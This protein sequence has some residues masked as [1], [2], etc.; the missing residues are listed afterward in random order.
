MKPNLIS[1]FNENRVQIRAYLTYLLERNIPTNLPS[2]SLDM[3]MVGIK[4]IRKEIDFLEAVYVL[5]AKGIQVTD[6]Y[7]PKKSLR[8]KDKGA[9][10]SSRAYYYRAVRQKKA[11]LTDPYPSLLTN[12]LSIST[13]MPIYNEHNKLLYVKRVLF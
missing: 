1:L 7:S 10:R 8:R 4:N 12:Q 6:T 2:I 9:N 13:A 3:I 5:D 11:I